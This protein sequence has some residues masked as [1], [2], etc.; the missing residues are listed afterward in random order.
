MSEVES[1]TRIRIGCAVHTAAIAQTS[2][3]AA[4]I[5]YGY[6]LGA[7]SQV[8]PNV[9]RCWKSSDVPGASEDSK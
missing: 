1:E 8:P 7:I 9:S 2:K 6:A 4:N 3:F 5:E